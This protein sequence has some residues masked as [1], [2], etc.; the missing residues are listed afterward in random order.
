MKTIEDIR[1]EIVKNMRN[2]VNHLFEEREY[3][4]QLDSL[5]AE[6]MTIQ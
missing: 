2:E 3:F 5:K 1:K 4:K 6:D